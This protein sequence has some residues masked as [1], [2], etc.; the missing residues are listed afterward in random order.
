MMPPTTGRIPPRTGVVN[1]PTTQQGLGLKTRNQGPGRQVQD[2]SYFQTE[3]RQKAN[4]IVEEIKRLKQSLEIQQ[5][6]NQNVSTFEKRADSLAQELRDLQNELGDLNTLI[7]KLSTDTA[8]E[9][10]EREFQDL[11]EK[12]QNTSQILDEMFLNRQ[13]RELQI[14]EMEQKIASE[15]QKQED[16]IQ[17][18][19]PERKEEYLKLKFDNQ[20]FIKAVEEQQKNIDGLQNLVLQSEREMNQNPNKK[21]AM[22]L[23]EKLTESKQKNS[24]LVLFLSRDNP[25]GPQER[26]RLLQQVKNDNLET[27]G[28]ERKIAEMMEEIRVMKDKLA[29]ETMAIDSTN[30]I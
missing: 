16:Q 28:M 5:K 7:D 12:N 3:L 26:E 4:A 6:E 29:I 21:R 23:F 24:E 19:V 20:E 18:L 15:Q 14:R 10:F 27:S 25:S 30:C 1:K 17:V 2:V 8:L 11:K 13:Q 9:D 22:A